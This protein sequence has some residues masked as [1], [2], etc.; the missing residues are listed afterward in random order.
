M[1]QVIIQPKLNTLTNLYDNNNLI[2][3]LRTPL[4]IEKFSKISLVNCVLPI[5]NSIVISVG[6][7]DSFNIVEGITTTVCTLT[8]SIYT[9]EQLCEHITTVI[10][11]ALPAPANNLNNISIVYDSRCNKV[12]FLVN[13]FMGDP[14]INP[15]QWSKI[16]ITFSTTPQIALKNILGYDSNTISLYPYIYEKYATFELQNLTNL[17]IEFPQFNF[18]TMITSNIGSNASIL[19][20]V[21]INGS[22]NV[23]FSPPVKI[24]LKL[25]NSDDMNITYIECN[26]LYLNSSGALTRFNSWQNDTPINITVLIEGEN[27]NED[28]QNE[29]VKNTIKENRKI[30]LFMNNN[31]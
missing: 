28:E 17:F 29:K 6:V 19:Y 31:I 13:Y 30:N 27:N 2:L 12:K 3:N 5:S 8:A 23:S 21:P 10:N 18:N 22:F 16:R 20:N 24:P 15:A 7:N 1:T 4:K 26:L 9:P 25:M 14:L 11:T